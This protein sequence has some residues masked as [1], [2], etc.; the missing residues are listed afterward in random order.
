MLGGVTVGVLAGCA[1]MTGGECTVNTALA[2]LVV[3]EKLPT[4]TE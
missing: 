4:T 2:L 3:P 1:V